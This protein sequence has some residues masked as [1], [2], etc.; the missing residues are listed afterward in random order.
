MNSIKEAITL[1]QSN[2]YRVSKKA[3]RMSETE[4]RKQTWTGQSSEGMK[5]MQL[6]F[7]SERWTW[8]VYHVDRYKSIVEGKTKEE[9]FEELDYIEAF[10]K[11]R[12]A[13]FRQGYEG[14]DLWKHGF[15]E[16]LNNYDD[17]LH[18]AKDLI[19]RKGWPKSIEKKREEVV[20][21]MEPNF[22][23]RRII[24]KKYGE[25]DRE[26]TNLPK[27]IQKEILEKGSA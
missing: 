14:P 17:Q 25:D 26:W 11:W 24:E 12:K 22:D 1:L 15:S 16:F 6:L 18:R 27:Y 4:K 21:Y 10:Y 7:H 5:R 20:V 13:L 2:G 9:F 23:W 8:K 19:D 3:R